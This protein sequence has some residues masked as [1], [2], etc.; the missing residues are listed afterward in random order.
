MTMKQRISQLAR[1]IKRMI[2]IVRRRETTV[3]TTVTLSIPLFLKVAI[4]CKSAPPKAANDNQPR[5][6]PRRNA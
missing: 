3:S 6:K 5:R 4:T 2:R 1:N